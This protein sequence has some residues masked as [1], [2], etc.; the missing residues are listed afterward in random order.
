ME[1][2]LATLLTKVAL[3]IIEALLI[4]LIQMWLRPG[5]D[6]LMSAPAL[7]AA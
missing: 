4:R 6:G 5:R 3:V 1:D 2:V 7:A